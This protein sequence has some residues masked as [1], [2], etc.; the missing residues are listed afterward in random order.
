VLVVEALSQ[1]RLNLGDHLAVKNRQQRRRRKSGESST[2]RMTRT[3]ATVV[4]CDHVEAVFDPLDERQQDFG[5]PGPDVD[6]VDFR[7]TGA[8][9]FRARGSRA[10]WV[11]RTTGRSGTDWSLMRRPKA[12]AFMSARRG[13]VMTRSNTRRVSWRAAS[14]FSAEE[15]QV[16][17][18]GLAEVEAA[19]LV[20]DALGQ[21][22]VLLHDPGIVERR[23]PAGCLRTFLAISSWKTLKLGLKLSWRWS[24]SWI[25]SKPS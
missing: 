17:R 12:T 19:V 5:V 1:G 2:K 8:S 20:N 7:R 10:P 14:A 11:R 25:T 13:M 18:G 21:A 4:S 16:R 22:A 15:T 3:P 23:R 6:A 9:S 24:Y